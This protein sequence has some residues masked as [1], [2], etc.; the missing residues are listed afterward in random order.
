MN[1]VAPPAKNVATPIPTTNGGV[2]G[3][4]SATP[5]ANMPVHQQF[6]VLEPLS[7]VKII[8]K[9]MSNILVIS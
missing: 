7:T 1:S 8:M 4:V 3:I 9:T 6:V 5:P 2:A